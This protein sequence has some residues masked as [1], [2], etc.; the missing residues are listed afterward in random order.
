MGPLFQFRPAYGRS[1]SIQNQNDLCLLMEGPARMLAGAVDVMARIAAERLAA[2]LE[3]S[4]FVVTKGPSEL[5][6]RVPSEGAGLIS[7]DDHRPGER[8]REWPVA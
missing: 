8:G 1:F 4:R 5:A 6:P 2:H 7:A 3:Q